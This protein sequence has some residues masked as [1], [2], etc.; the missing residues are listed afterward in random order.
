MTEFIWVDVKHG[1]IGKIFDER[2]ERYHGSIGTI[3][4]DIIT[5]MI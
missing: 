2:N 5:Y 1:D 3:F 4:S